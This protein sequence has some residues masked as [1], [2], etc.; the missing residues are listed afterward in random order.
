V[1]KFISWQA[2]VELLGVLDTLRGSL[3]EKRV[4]F[5]TEK[6]NGLHHFNAEDR[7]QIGKM[8]DELIDKL[9]I[10]PAERLRTEKELRKKIQSVEAI[11][12]LYLSEREKP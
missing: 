8:M 4:A 6:L 9:L 11:R 12:A 7:E 1:G 2:S 10:A 5:L 3:K